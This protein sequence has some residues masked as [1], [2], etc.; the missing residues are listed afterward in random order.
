[1][2][3]VAECRFVYEKWRV[4]QDAYRGEGEK[5]GL[6]SPSAWIPTDESQSGGISCYEQEDVLRVYP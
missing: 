4:G 3:K 5:Y 6:K 2:L 1:M